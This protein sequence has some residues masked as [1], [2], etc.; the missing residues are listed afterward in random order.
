MRWIKNKARVSGL[1][2]IVLVTG[3]ALAASPAT[4]PAIRAATQPLPDLSEYRT[5]ATAVL[6]A[7]TTA[8]T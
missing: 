4:Q 1:L 6:A 2:A 3:Q 7:P 8:P 5:V